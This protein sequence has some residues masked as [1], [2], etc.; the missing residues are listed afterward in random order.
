MS[1]PPPIPS[2][3]L[4][5]VTTAPMAFSTA[6][7]PS[8]SVPLVASS[9]AAAT[10]MTAPST[11]PPAATYTPEEITEVL[12]DL[13]AA[14]QGIRLYLAGPYGPPPRPGQ[15]P[16]RGIRHPRRRPGLYT[17]T[18]R[19]SRRPPPCPN[20]RSGRRR[21]SPRH[22]CHPGPRRHRPGS[23]GSRRT[24]R[25]PRRWSGRCSPRCSYNQPPPPPRSG[26]NGRPRPSP[27]PSPPPFLGSC[28]CR[29]LRRPAT[30]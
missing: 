15:P 23:L 8:P 14:V 29:R 28:C 24:P 16:G 21:P 27:P 19:F 30:G 4:P 5:T 6:P 10:Q 12:N 3:P 22:P 17:T 13:V 11:A 26:H 1:S 2:L 25:P 9:G 7:L 18:G 20:G